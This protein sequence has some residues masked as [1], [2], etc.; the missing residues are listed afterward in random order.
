MES[1]LKFQMPSRPHPTLKWHRRKKTAQSRVTVV[2]EVRVSD[3]W[4][5]RTPMPKFRKRIAVPKRRDV[6]QSG[7]EH[8]SYRFVYLA[9]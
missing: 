3:G 8:C 2:R 7:P 5:E 9:E 4:Q 1:F 6:V